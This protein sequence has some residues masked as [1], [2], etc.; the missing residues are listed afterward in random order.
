VATNKKA[1]WENSK[2]LT[3]LGGLLASTAY[4]GNL[5]AWVTFPT[6]LLSIGAGIVSMGYG[7]F[8]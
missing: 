4:I 5:M 2:M 8:G 1:H 3:V 7:F 6:M